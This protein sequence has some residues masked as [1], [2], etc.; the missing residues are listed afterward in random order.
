LAAMGHPSGS[1][2]TALINSWYSKLEPLIALQVDL[3]SWETVL[4]ICRSGR[5]FSATL[6][7]DF[8]TSVAPDL[9]DKLNAITFR[10]FCAS[11]G[12]EVTRE[13]KEPITEAFPKDD[14][15]FLKRRLYYS[16]EMGRYVGALDLD[17]LFDSFCWVRTDDPSDTDLRGTFNM[18]LCELAL[19]GSAVYDRESRRIVA[20]AIKTLK[21]PFAP[22]PWHVAQT[23]VKAIKDEYRP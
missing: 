9:Q 6:G 14:P 13:N 17:A 12:M 7:D 21:Q 20:A 8:I 2:L 1:F 10:D 16:D 11:Y 18:A 22:L 3:Q 19:H 15:V 23:A 4:E 5:V